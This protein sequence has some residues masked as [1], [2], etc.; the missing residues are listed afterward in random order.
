MPND[1]WKVLPHGRLE[2]LE[3]NLW[4]VE[5]AVPGMPLKR[6]MTVARLQRGGLVVHN[7]MALA[8]E[9]MRELESLGNIEF[10]IVPNRWHRLDAKAFGTR[11]PNAQVIAP[12]GGKKKVSEVIDPHGGS[13]LL[14]SDETVSLVELDGTKGH[15]FV[16]TVRSPSGGTTLV[17]TDA[18]FNMPHLPGAQGF[19]LK[20]ITQSSG[21]P[22]V[23]RVARLFLI[24]DKRAFASHLERLAT[25]ELT[26]IIVAHHEVISNEPAQTLQKLAA[27]L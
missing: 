17:F 11:Y 1:S 19:I 22:C 4:R 24:K 26:R 23:S 6:V 7:A 3:E 2:K 14:P 25:P 18:V 21:G 10:I 8:E 13:E 27:S 5:G 16:M 9:T 12:S 20:H 15:E